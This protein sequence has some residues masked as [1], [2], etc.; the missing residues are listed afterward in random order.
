MKKMLFAL[1]VTLSTFAPLSGAHAAT[2]PVKWIC[3][4]TGPTSCVGATT[5]ELIPLT[6]DTIAT[7][8]Q[9]PAKPVADCF[10]LYPTMSPAKSWNAPNRVTRSIRR[11]VRAMALPFTRTC[12]LV[13]PV[14]QQVTSSHL[15]VAAPTAKDRA[16]IE[17]AYQ[18]VLRGW[19]AYL[20]VTPSTRPVILVGFSQGAGML[21]QLL[22]REIAP[23]PKQLHRVILSELVGGGLT[24][25]SPRSVTDGLAGIA[26]C[27]H[28]GRIRCAIAFDAFTTQPSAHAIVGRPGAPWGYLSA[29]T[30]AQGSQMACVNPVYGGR[31]SGPLIPYL[32]GNPYTTYANRFRAACERQGGIDWLDIRQVDVPN[33]GGHRNPMPSLDPSSDASPTGLH[34]ESWGL[35]LGNLV[36]SARAAVSK[37]DVRP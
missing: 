27:P 23:N 22:R 30:P 8:Y 14:Y 6:G 5:T 20:K 29:W 21:S 9:P 13:V 17:V 3:P 37:W 28:I 19:R 36:L 33:F 2:E 34:G 12:R 16:A 31:L 11:A 32:G 26:L 35:T 18:S 24:I 15:A 1:T 10:F 4:P 25:T 7:T